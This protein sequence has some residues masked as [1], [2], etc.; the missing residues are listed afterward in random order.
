[1][2]LVSVMV[3]GTVG[4]VARWGVELAVPSVGG[5][6]LATFL[7]NVTGAFGLGLV[8]VVL[9]ERLPPT[10]H[11]RPLLMIGFFGAYTTFSTMAMEGVRLLD[12]GHSALAVGYWVITLL[13]GQ[14][15]GVYGMWLGRLR[16]P[17]RRHATARRSHAG[18]DLHR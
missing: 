9:L 17:G 10:R 3:G 6:P 18:A 12:Q 1:M 4:A 2:R 13:I 5:F 15:A 8:G 7:I 14:M 11:L 16:L